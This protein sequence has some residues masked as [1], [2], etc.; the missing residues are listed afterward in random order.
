MSV[1]MQQINNYRRSFDIRACLMIVCCFAAFDFQILNCTYTSCVCIHTTVE[2]DS[3][4]SPKDSNLPVALLRNIC[5]DAILLLS[6]S[7]KG[8]V[9]QHL[10]TND[11]L[12]Q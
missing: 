3:L 1:G 5:S 11:L 4:H 7:F 2:I 12:K 10:M 9:F 6:S 8:K